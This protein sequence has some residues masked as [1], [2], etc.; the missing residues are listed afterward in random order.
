MPALRLDRKQA[1]VLLSAHACLLSVA[2]ITTCTTAQKNAF[3]IRYT[4]DKRPN[5]LNKAQR[6]ELRSAL[7]NSLVTVVVLR[8]FQSVK[9]I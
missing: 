4:K 9:L 3:S 7:Y 5:C 2:F 1:C 8:S 6:R